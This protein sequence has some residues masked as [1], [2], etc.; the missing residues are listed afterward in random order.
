MLIYNSYLISEL[1]W[2][3]TSKCSKTCNILIIFLC[4]LP[5][6][7]TKMRIKVK[8]AH[9]WPWLLINC[10]VASYSFCNCASKQNE[11]LKGLKTW[12]TKSNLICEEEE[13]MQYKVERSR[14]Y[15]CQRDICTT[16]CVIIH[17]LLAQSS[18]GRGLR[19]FGGT[20]NACAIKC[21][22]PTIQYLY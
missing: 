8:W 19:T 3:L 15:E 12:A 2:I 14:C 17:E 18:G 1:S 21:L 7:I 9:S 13:K 11:Q 4:A 20:N 16:K 10:G 5:T 6:C 22:N